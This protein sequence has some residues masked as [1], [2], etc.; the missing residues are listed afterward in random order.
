M[1]S[2]IIDTIYEM[3]TNIETCKETIE[4]VQENSSNN[5]EIKFTTNSWRQIFGKENK[6]EISKVLL[7]KILEQIKEEQEKD[8]DNM[9]GILHKRKGENNE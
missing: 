1:E 9:I 2:K 5:I 7:T 6:I 8:L 4:R 3:K